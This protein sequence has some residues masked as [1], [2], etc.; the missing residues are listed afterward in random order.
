MKNQ[1]VQRVFLFLAACVVLA[2]GIYGTLHLRR[3]SEAPMGSYVPTPPNAGGGFITALDVDLSAQPSQLF[4][5][6]TTYTIDG[7]QWAKSGTA[8]E[9]SFMQLL[10]GQGIVIQPAATAVLNGGTI[11]FPFIGFGLSSLLGI[12][13]QYGSTPFRVWAHVTASNLSADGDQ[14]FL[15][16]QDSNDGNAAVYWIGESW[17]T[18]DTASEPTA[19]S[20]F[21]GS[22]GTPSTTSS[23]SNDVFVLDFPMGMGGPA[24]MFSGSWSS[25]WPAFNTLFYRRS[26]GITATAS[27]LNSGNAQ[28]FGVGIGAARNGSGTAVSVTFANFKAE[29]RL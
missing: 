11:N 20:I 7:K 8:Y 2:T 9:A 10:N 4:P 6:N 28:D 1:T 14:L 23:A 19:N 17:V 18:G 12:S 24:F 25:G 29:Y 27:L 3:S 26:E 16:V 5:I 15:M 21:S 13:P 22:L